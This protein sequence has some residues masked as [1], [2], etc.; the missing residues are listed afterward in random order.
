MATV[1]TRVPSALDQ[2]IV[3]NTSG[4]ELVG[5]GEEIAGEDLTNDVLKVEQRF[6]YLNIST[7][8]TTVVKSGAGF[9]H[10]IVVNKHVATGVITIYDNTAG[11]GTKIAT[12]TTGA[13]L[14]SDSPICSLYNVSFSTGLTI[15]TSQAE[16]LTVSYR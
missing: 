16:D 15:V 14:T 11:S 3:Q 8:T 4:M 12:I 10:L 7:A 5:L 13:A 1:A 9:L 2:S 6:N